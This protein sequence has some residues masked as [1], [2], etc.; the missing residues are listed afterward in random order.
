MR[1]LMFA[2]ALLP[3]C[4]SAQSLLIEFTNGTSVSHPIIDVRSTDL[5]STTMRVHLWNG[6]TEVHER[7]AIARCEFVGSATGLSEKVDGSLG[8]EVFPNPSSGPVRITCELNGHAPVRAEILEIS[9]KLV[10]TLY[11]GPAAGPSLVLNWNGTNDAGVA[12]P[13]ENY[14]CRIRQGAGSATRQIVIQ[15]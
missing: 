12:V 14:L 1:Q 4:I 15:H 10:R 7:S 5:E 9:G 6:N 11:Q 13:D 8:M 3:S 2:F